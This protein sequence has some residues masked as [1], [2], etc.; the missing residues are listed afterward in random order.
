MDNA[1]KRAAIMAISSG[2]TL[3][4]PSGTVDASAR[5][6]FLWT[7]VPGTTGGGGGGGGGLVLEWRSSQAWHR[8]YTAP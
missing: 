8:S 1:A 4:R 3:P 6:H 5:F 2:E 7:Y